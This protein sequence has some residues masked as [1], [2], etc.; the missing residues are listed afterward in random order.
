MNRRWI[1]CLGGSLLAALS[2]GQVASVGHGAYRFRAKHIRGAANRY[3]ATTQIQRITVTNKIDEKVTGLRNGIA[4]LQVAI[5]PAT[6]SAPKQTLSFAQ[7]NTVRV[8]SLNH[9]VGS[10][11]IPNILAE[12]PKASIR[13][14]AVWTGLS[15]FA[16]GMGKGG[17][18]ATSYRFSSINRSGGKTIAVLDVLLRGI[19]NGSGAMLIDASDGSMLASSLTLRVA[20][21]KGQYQTVLVRVR[22]G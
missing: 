2:L 12:F 7:K 8:D 1:G 11:G 4:T 9:P 3:T 15:S 21:G 17:S 19:A 18:L 13:P 5:G 10:S 6:E 22:R 20:T 14:G 16:T